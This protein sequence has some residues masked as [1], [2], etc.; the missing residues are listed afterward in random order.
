MVSHGNRV[1]RR[2][3]RSHPFPISFDFFDFFDFFARGVWQRPCPAAVGRARF[4]RHDAF[5]PPRLLQREQAYAV[6]LGSRQHLG[7]RAGAS[8]ESFAQPG[9]HG[10]VRRSALA[11]G[12]GMEKI[13]GGVGTLAF[14][15]DAG[16][17]GAGDGVEAK[18]EGGGGLAEIGFADG[19]DAAGRI[20]GVGGEVAEDM[21]CLPPQS[22]GCT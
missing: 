6:G 14:P 4:A 1:W 11:I 12:D 3:S 13:G 19:Q 18:G 20:V 21:Y 2:R 17:A 10:I 7:G 15:D 8:G 16:D 22:E 9:A 5:D